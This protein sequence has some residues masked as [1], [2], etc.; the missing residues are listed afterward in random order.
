M[1]LGLTEIFKK[2]TRKDASI[3]AKILAISVFLIALGI[4]YSL[5]S[6]GE[7]DIKVTAEAEV[8]ETSLPA[9]DK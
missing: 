4:M 7:V 6:R 8:E 5:I 1:R 3:C 9:A 2:V